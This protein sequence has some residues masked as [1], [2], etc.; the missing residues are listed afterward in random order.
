MFPERK[1]IPV[2]EKGIGRRYMALEAVW[3]CAAECRTVIAALDDRVDGRWRRT[4]N[5]WMT[6]SWLSGL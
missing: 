5:T 1:M 3:Y 4:A 2:L 6:A